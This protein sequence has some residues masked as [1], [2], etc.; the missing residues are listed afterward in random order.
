MKKFAVAI[1]AAAANAQEW[2]SFEIT[3]DGLTKG[4]FSQS[5]EFSV[6][7]IEGKSMEIMGNNSLSIQEAQQASDSSAYKPNLMG[8]SI[9]Y[10]V[11]LAG[12]NSGCVAGVYLVESDNSR[13][14]PNESQDQK[15]QC[16][17]IDAMQANKYGFESKAHPCSNGTCD[18]ISQ[19]ALSMQHEAIQ[20]SHHDCYG[21][22]GSKIDTNKRFHVKNEY[23][24]TTD[25]ANFWKLRTIIS[26][27]DRQI[28][29]EKDC[30]DYLVGL[31]S[32]ISGDMSIVFSSWDNLDG[33]ED[34]EVDNGQSK[35]STC[36]DAV[37]VIENFTVNKIG[38]TEDP[39]DD[40]DPNPNPDPNPDP[41]PQ[42]ESVIVDFEAYTDYYGGDWKMYALGLEG[43]KLEG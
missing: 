28:V 19:C 21:P 16:K 35:A 29:M 22:G 23:V 4:M 36:S 7:Y 18:A 17:S 2:E 15:P 31:Q 11:N 14:S 34:F 40:T 42:P 9:E 33:V 3:Q 30:R 27:D 24:S 39:K 12:V 25:Y 26:Q 37:H 41:E 1:I 13:C 8:G 10:D 38:S 43:V 20:S 5:K 6:A 32:P